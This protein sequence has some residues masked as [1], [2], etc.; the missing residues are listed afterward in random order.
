MPPF[1]LLWLVYQKTVPIGQKVEFLSFIP[2]CLIFVS[3]G[4][5]V[6]NARNPKYYALRLQIV[7]LLCPKTKVCAAV[8]TGK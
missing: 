1:V 6:A 2:L 5:F 3:C 4:Y 8:S 7:H